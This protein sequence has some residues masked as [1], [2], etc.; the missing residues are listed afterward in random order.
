MAGIKENMLNYSSSGENHEIERIL[1]YMGIDCRLKSST[2]DGKLQE[3][4]RRF[5]INT[6]C[7]ELTDDWYSKMLLPVLVEQNGEYKAVLPNYSGRGIMYKDGKRIRLD[8]KNA[9]DIGD[10]GRCFYKGF[11]EKKITR[12]G[13]VKYMLSCVRPQEYAVIFAAAY[14]M[15]RFARRFPRAQYTIFN[16]VIPSGTADNIMPIA[17]LLMGIALIYAVLSVFRGIVSSNM[18]L[19]IGANFQSALVSRLLKL[20]PSFFSERRSGSLSR[21]IVRFSD[22]SG[23]FSCES[24]TALFSLVLSYIYA[25]EIKRYTPEMMEWVYITFAGIVVSNLVYALLRGLYLSGLYKCSNEMTGFVYELFGG[26][27]NVKLNNA[28]QIMTQRWNEQYIDTM[29]AYS[30]N[31]YTKNYN[32]SYLFFGSI[33]MIVFYGLGI[34]QHTSA[35]SFAAFLSLYNLFVVSAGGI[36]SVLQSLMKFNTAYARLKDFL[37]AEIEEDI[38]KAPIKK[39]ESKIEFSGVS[40]K[41]PSAEKNVLEN[42]S[43]KIQ[44]GEKIGIVGKSGSGKSTLLKL[45]LGFE[46][47]DS[48]RIFIDDTDLNEIDLKSYRRNLGVVLQTTKLIPGDIYSNLTLINANVDINEIN[49]A[50]TAVGIKDDIDNMPMGLH[51]YVSE[52]NMTV[53]AGQKQRIVLARAIL[54]KPFMLVL[55][56]ATNALDNITQAR[57]TEYLRSYDSTVV[58]VAHRLST[59]KYCDR[60]IVLNNGTIAEE[61]NYN[62]LME[63][64]G[65]FYE[66]IKNQL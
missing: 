44:K 37:N 66:L 1:R 64:Q 50:L 11:A 7:V 51:T 31:R 2:V 52:N 13:L 24:I 28:S 54:A 8:K 21:T 34:K 45:L 40:Y 33:V 15:V 61:G 30:K 49:E 62:E 25:A 43:F 56:E 59:I 48:G 12:I 65:F 9:S 38:D 4:K 6:R 27:E 10:T 17:M 29:K 41:Y 14:F 63:K 57:V 3:I 46:K 55:D 60:I 26:M 23:I 39:I 22:I 32:S 47:P 20:K 19:I 18:S 58:L 36:G 16:S 5:D 42:I 35:A 53:S